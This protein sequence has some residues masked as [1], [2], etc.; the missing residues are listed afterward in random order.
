MHKK[1]HALALLLP[2]IFLLLMNEQCLMA[3]TD[4]GSGAMYVQIILAGIAGG[5]FRICSLLTRFR[6][7]KNGRVNVS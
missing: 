1:R 2:L 4:P 7:K 3:Y 6:K 5:V